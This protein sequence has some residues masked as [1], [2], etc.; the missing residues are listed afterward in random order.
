MVT[1]VYNPVITVLGKQRQKDHEFY[2]SFVY[3]L[4]LPRPCLKNQTQNSESKRLQ[5]QLQRPQSE[6]GIVGTKTLIQLGVGLQS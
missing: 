1:H 2:T 6:V 5:G 4:R 3:L